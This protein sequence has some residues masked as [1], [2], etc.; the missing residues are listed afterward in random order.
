M[1][2]ILT[3]GGTGGHL[4]PGLALAREIKDKNPD[5]QIL[6][7][8]TT[9]GFDSVQ[10]KHSGFSYQPVPAARLSLSPFFPVRFWRA[11]RQARQHFEEF[12]PDLVVGLGGYGSVPAILAAR[13][14]DIPVVLMEQNYFPGKI[15]R[16]FN[17]RAREIYVQWAGSE[18][19]F[20]DPS[21]V[22]VTGSPLRPEITRLNRVTT[23]QKLKISPD[24]KILVVMGGSQGAHALNQFMIDHRSVLDKF[25]DQI[26]LIHLTGDTD[27]GLVRQGYAGTKIERQVF[28]F[29]DRMGEI[30]SVADLVLSR[31]GA[32]AIAELTHLEIPSVLIPY[33]H[34]AN[35]HQLLNAQ[36]VAEKKA[37]IYIEQKDIN[38]DKMTY[39]IQEVLLKD[40]VLKEMSRNT[41][42][43][44][45]PNA[46]S[47]IHNRIQN[48]INP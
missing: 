8:C 3:G 24:K 14:R 15:T 35:N 5:A 4:F 12:Q 27:Y 43:L 39:L 44:A 23:A 9:R 34:A 22:L 1:K 18:K 38:L 7:L 11:Y 19:Y 40:D 13:R 26:A 37:G 32:L 46:A 6:F 16:Y 48:L 41:K 28:T 30:Y 10:L 2:I 33:P 17:R 45:Y 21:K 20:K 31:A 29:S 42:S 25:A 47:T 36:K